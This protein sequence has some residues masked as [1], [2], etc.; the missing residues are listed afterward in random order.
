MTK[1]F[2][3]TLKENELDALVKIV[4]RSLGNTNDDARRKMLGLLHDELAATLEME[5]LMHAKKN[6]NQIRDNLE[7]AKKAAKRKHLQVIK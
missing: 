5:A 7:K 6:L 3:V 2:T 1:M 4:R